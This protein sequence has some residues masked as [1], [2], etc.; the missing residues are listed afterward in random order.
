M[1]KTIVIDTGYD[2]NRAQT[3]TTVKVRN[4][5]ACDLSRR[6]FAIVTIVLRFIIAVDKSEKVGITRFTGTGYC[7]STPGFTYIH[8]P[9]KMLYAITHKVDYS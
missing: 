4:G 7:K 3:Q 9:Y 1:L 6:L 5:Y 8:T 2:C